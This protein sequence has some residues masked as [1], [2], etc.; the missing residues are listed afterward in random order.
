MIN[1]SSRQKWYRLQQKNLDNQFLN[2]ISDG[3]NMTPF[4]AK[5]T[6][7][8]VHE[9]YGD[10]FEESTTLAPGQSRFVVLSA[11]VS[12]SVEL[13]KAEQVTVILTIN[14]DTEDL[15]VKK[16]GGTVALRRHRL[17]R[18]AHEAFMQGGLLTVEDLANR[19]FCCGERTIIRDLQY[20]RKEGLLI[21]LR[22]TIK[23][24]G[25]T[26]SHRSLIVKHWCMGDE[27]SEIARKTNHS[28]NAISNYVRKFK[29][30]VVLMKE[31]Y[32]VHTIAFLTRISKKLA[33]E[34]IDIYAHSDIVAARKQEL[35]D[36]L[37]KNL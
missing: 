20:F 18:I 6:L 25:R 23:D 5:A 29:Q 10:F 12:P 13:K 3:L 16:S 30:A 34:Y 8:S 21:P 19:V 15:P 17:Q 24:M 2:K 27:Y 9:V 36:L 7:D 22:S 35:E 26:L 31:G 14:N 32:E 37:K 4:E 28:V 1:N 33:E 11:E